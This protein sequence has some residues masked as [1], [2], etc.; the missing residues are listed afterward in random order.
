MFDS[1][2]AWDVYVLTALRSC[3][4][5]WA[6]WLA[7]A[8]ATAAW[9]G[10]FFWGVAALLLIIGRRLFAV[11]LAGSLLLGSLLVSALKGVVAR[12]RP[13]LYSSIQLNI[14]MPELLSTQHSFPSGHT[15]LAAAAAVGK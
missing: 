1:I 4:D 9:K 5:Q 6:V 10:F 11:Q 2:Q 8:F 12:P 7:W 13:D 3:H 15:L 14:P